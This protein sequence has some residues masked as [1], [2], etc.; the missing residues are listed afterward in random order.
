MTEFI[1]KFTKGT[2]R[3]YVIRSSWEEM[4]KYI[5]HKEREG[6][7]LEHCYQHEG[8]TKKAEELREKRG[9][10]NI[11][12]DSYSHNADVYYWASKE[13]KEVLK[14]KECK[15][16][17]LIKKFFQLFCMILLPINIY[18]Y[19]FYVDGIYYNITSSTL[20]Y[21]ANV[22]SYYYGDDYSGKVTIPSNV[23]YDNITY[24]VTSIGGFA[25]SHCSGLTS[26]TIPNSVTSIGYNAFS[27]CS[28]LTS[29]TI[30][31]S[32]TSIGSYAFE[33]C[34]GLTSI[35]IGNSVTSI[36]WYAFEDCSALTRVD[37]TDLA[38]WCK[39]SFG[40]YDANPCYYAHHLYLNN[41]EITELVIPNS[42]TSIGNYAFY[43]CSGLTSV[44][45]P[46]SVTSIGNRAFSYC[47]GLTSVD[48][49]DLEAWCN[50]SFGSYD[51]NPCY[52]AHH[53]YL[54]NEEITELVIPNSVTSIGN[55]AFYNCLGLTSIT[56]PNSVTSIGYDAFYGCT[57]VKK[58]IYAEGTTTALKTGLASITDLT[59]PSSV[60]SIGES[61][62]SSCSYL[63]SIKVGWTRPL[64]VA[65]GTFNSKIYSTATLYVPK[66]TSTL[67]MVAPEWTKFVNIAEYGDA[68]GLYLTIKQA[69]SGC[70]KQEVTMGSSYT[71][72]IEPSEGW[73]MHSVSFNGTDVTGQ[74]VDGKYITPAI[75]KD[76][77]LNIVFKQGSSSVKEVEAT[78]NVKVAANGGTLNISGADE[79]DYVKVY[80]MNGSLVESAKGNTSFPLGSGVYIIR[81]GNETFKVAM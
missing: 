30:P 65:D 61:A 18:A 72:L 60:T 15:F 51:A 9:E 45:I 66:G 38:A 79:S 19:D 25:F 70:V 29:V 6:C 16:C 75:T 33:D 62:F 53:L 1:A 23:T 41:E 39:I 35:T 10:K 4:D 36:G 26:I 24:S 42:V 43:N 11:L 63:E 73:S 48:I 58:L 67:Y 7:A 56:I 40:S 32:V 3:V 76:S 68:S 8:I 77:E 2:E 50:I 54:N 27:H 5:Q 80:S 78:H 46:N 20:P 22:M 71:F 64:A 14:T 47:S 37:I 74:V 12:P 49:T 34:S 55:Y 21:T 13:G 31:N 69:D 17:T 28:G 44:T 59:I 57:N 52:Y 81:V